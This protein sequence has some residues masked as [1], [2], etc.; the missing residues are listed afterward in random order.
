MKFAKIID[1]N[2]FHHIHTH[3]RAHTKGNNVR[4]W[5][6]ELTCMVIISQCIC[7][8]GYHIHRIYI[9]FYVNYTS[10]KLEKKLKINNK[11]AT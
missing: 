5:T 6:C 10:I 2:Q 8:S 7:L 3:T 1:F 4:L 9:Q 11:K